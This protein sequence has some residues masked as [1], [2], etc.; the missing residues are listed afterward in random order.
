M[1]LTVYNVCKVKK[2]LII[3]QYIFEPAFNR[4]I[5]LSDAG[6]RGARGATALPPI[7]GNPV[8]PIPTGEGRL[9]PPI[10]TGTPKVF[11]LPASLLL[12]QKK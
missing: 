2:L 11:H 6:T 9:S 5:L 8:N 1:S 3:S 12:I 4:L 10:A 7:F